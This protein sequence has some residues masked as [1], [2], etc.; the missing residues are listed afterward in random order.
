ME[1]KCSTYH[2]AR[3]TGRL[4]GT[5]LAVCLG[6]V[7]ERPCEVS[8]GI[9]ERAGFEASPVDKQ[10]GNRTAEHKKH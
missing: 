8:I 2:L 9:A 6:Q 3:N 10:R 7:A 5:G 1:F 4:Q